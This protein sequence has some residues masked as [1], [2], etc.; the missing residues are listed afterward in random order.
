[1]NPAL[2]GGASEGPSEADAGW[3]A[4]SRFAYTFVPY[5]KLQQGRSEAPNPNQLAIDVHLGTLHVAGT[6]PS[7]TSLDVQLPFGSLRTT[8][9]EGTVTDTGLG[10]LELRVR[11]ATP[12]SWRVPRLTAT[13]GLALPTGPYV[14][15][16]GAA[17]LPPEAA[18]LTLGRGVAWGIGELEVVLRA[19]PRASVFAQTSARLPL[20]RTSDAFD[21]GSELRA[22]VGGSVRLSARWSALASTDLTWRGGASEPDPFTMTRIE[23]ANAGGWWWSTTPSIRFDLGGGLAAT[24]G[25]RVSLAAD[26]VGNQLVPQTGGFVALAYTH[27][28]PPPAARSPASRGAVPGRITVVD[29]WATWCT[30]CKQIHADL[31]AARARWPDVTIERVDATEWPGPTAPTLP[32]GVTGLPAIEVFDRKGV[33]THLLVGPDASRIVEIVDQLRNEVS[34]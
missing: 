34:P 12:R 22:T 20:H 24:A 29:Y 21:W 5:G 11:Q 23:S 8:T 9:F 10:D 17:N 32:A 33:R 26:V 14:A 1:M 4:Q 7:G 28:V 13:V 3:S 2:P 30:A 6:A 19:G 18:T 27:R 15:R 31:E 25:V 16:S